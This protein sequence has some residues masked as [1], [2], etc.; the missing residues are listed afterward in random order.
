MGS[1]NVAPLSEVKEALL[2]P[3][4]YVLDVRTRE[5]IADSGHVQHPRWHQVNG[6]PDRCSDL[7]QHPEKLVPDKAA[8]I[9]V[10]CR[11]GR[12]AERAKQALVQN[13][14]TGTILNGGGYDQLKG[15]LP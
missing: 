15:L 11:S 2:D 14:Y 13:G 3:T 6:T 5:E 8:N 12:R 10:Y 7:D 9:V 1:I 4:T